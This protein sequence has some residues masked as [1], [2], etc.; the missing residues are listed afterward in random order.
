MMTDLEDK[1]SLFW[2]PLVNAKV[3]VENE[4]VMLSLSTSWL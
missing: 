4:D 3:S 2:A 1:V